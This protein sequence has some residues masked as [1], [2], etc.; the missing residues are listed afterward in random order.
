MAVLQNDFVTDLIAQ[1][2]VHIPANPFEAADARVAAAVRTGQDVMDLSKG[3]PDGAPPDF[4]SSTAAHAAYDSSDFRYP[5]FD[6]KPAFL[7]AAAGWY[8]RTHGVDLDP[9][10]Q[11]LAVAGSSVG[12][13][14]TILTLVNAGDLVV[15]PGPYYPQYAGSTAVA[16]GHIQALPTTAEQGFLPDLDAVPAEVWDRTKLL[17]LNYPNNPTG[18]ATTPGFF[19]TAVRLAKRRHFIIM[20]DFAY[21]GIGFDKQPPISLL[22]TPGAADVSV[23]LCSLSKMYMVAGW[24]GGFIAGNAHLIHA[25]KSIHYQTSLLM[26]SIVQ[27]T[28]TVALNSDQSTVQVLADRYHRRFLTLQSGLAEAGLHVCDSHGGLFAWMAVP[29]G[30]SD[31]GFSDWLLHTAGVAVMAG[32]NFGPTGVGYVRLS[33]LKTE[34]ELAEAAR[35]IVQAMAAA[36]R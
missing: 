16:Q 6:G 19:A 27:D 11:L 7:K 5:P 1:R 8:G 26:T 25:I 32:S 23:E 13:S 22:S 34:D 31:D 12:I 29:A 17:I 14:E 20:H 10:T 30:Q 28:G 15:A 3:N 21:V 24:R 33:L 4:V 35:R 2:A 18:A 36:Q 9:A